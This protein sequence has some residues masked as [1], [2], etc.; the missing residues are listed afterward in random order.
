[1]V[2]EL[3]NLDQLNKNIFNVR[4]NYS[5]VRS[6]LWRSNEREF[7]RGCPETKCVRR[8]DKYT[9]LEGF[10]KILRWTLWRLLMC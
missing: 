9:V 1:M 7:P 4:H 2:L 10:L 6:D 8:A 5:P 3:Q